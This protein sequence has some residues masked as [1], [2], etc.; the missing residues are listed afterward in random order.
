M[1]AKADR[2]TQPGTAALR[3]AGNQPEIRCH[4][5]QLYR[6]PKGDRTEVDKSDEQRI[7]RR[8]NKGGPTVGRAPVPILGRAQIPQSVVLC[9][10][11][12]DVFGVD[13]PNLKTMRTSRPTAS[14]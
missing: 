3:K 4:L 7:S 11:P 14:P 6:D 9:R 10:A 2:Q 13:K 5:E 8:P 12:I 1:A